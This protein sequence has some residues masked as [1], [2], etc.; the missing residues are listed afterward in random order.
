MMRCA[1]ISQFG[2]LDVIET[3]QVAKPVPAADEVLVKVKAAGV[4]FIDTYM[5]SGLYPSELPL[6]LGK[7]GAGEI[8]ATGADVDTLNVGDRVAFFVPRGAFAELICVKAAR[9]LPCPDAVSDETAAAS[10]LQGLTAHYLCHDTHHVG[11][12]STVLVWAAAGGTGG[13]LVQMCKNLG[14]RVVAIAGGP[15][16]AEAAR[17]LGADAVVD[18]KN[19]ADLD[20]AIAEATQGQGV[21]V[22]FDG[23][24]KSSFETS[25]KALRPLGHLVTFGNA[26]G[27]VPP[28]EPLALMRAGSI[29]LTRPSL[30]HYVATDEAL[31]TR[32]KAVFDMLQSGAVTVRIGGT[33]S[34]DQVAKAQEDLLSGTTQGKLLVLPQ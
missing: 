19:V 4:N 25:L 21:T 29:T 18:Y 13:L 30:R 33:C 7:E 34:L 6:I 24:G 11:P 31:R 2:A 1:R 16:K 26:S 10:V 15:A 28:V 22:V 27:K 20:A 3:V 23:V 12:E 8:V 17:E 14:A 9:A 5:R 32:A